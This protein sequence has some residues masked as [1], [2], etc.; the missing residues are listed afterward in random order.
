MTFKLL[1]CKYLWYISA[2]CI[3]HLTV[4]FLV[5]SV[6][7]VSCRYCWYR[8]HN[9]ILLCGGRAEFFLRARPGT[10]FMFVDYVPC[11]AQYRL[12]GLYAVQQ[13]NASKWLV[14]HSWSSCKSVALSRLFSSDTIVLCLL[15]L[16][17][18]E[19]QL[20]IAWNSAVC[21]AMVLIYY[22]DGAVLVVGD[23]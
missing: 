8:T 7:L 17:L 18:G 14:P 6:S 20:L 22:D 5:L 1:P 4:P 10:D 2:I 12:H 15:L 23:G 21:V 11:I 9:G 13:S 19:P 16:L 3:L